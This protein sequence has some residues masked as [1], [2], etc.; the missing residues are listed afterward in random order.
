[1]QTTSE[2]PLFVRKVAR[3]GSRDIEREEI[4]QIVRVAVDGLLAER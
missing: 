1:M 4:A 2:A 3:D